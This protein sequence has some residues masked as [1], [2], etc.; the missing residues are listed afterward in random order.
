LPGAVISFLARK[1]GCCCLWTAGRF[2]MLSA[3]EWAG[4]I[5][6][7]GRTEPLAT[8]RCRASTPKPKLPPATRARSNSLR[9][10][11]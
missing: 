4:S 1:S 7:G 8:G 5:F 9:F 11:L 6:K 2:H 3:F 10:L